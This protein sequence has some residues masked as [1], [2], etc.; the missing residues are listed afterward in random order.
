MELFKD[1]YLMAGI[2]LLFVSFGG[3]FWIA[4]SIQK[5]QEKEQSLPDSFSD[6]FT[7]PAAS[8][9]PLAARSS[10]PPQPPVPAR[11]SAAPVFITTA[12]PAAPESSFSAPPEDSAQIRQMRAAIEQIASQLEK[13]EGQMQTIAKKLDQPSPASA[14]AQSGAGNGKSGSAQIAELS[15]KIEKIYQVLATLSGSS[16]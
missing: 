5:K 15:T 1:V 4:R 16:R 11:P 9:P 14:D 2:A 3:I 6:I 10:I 8:A 7:A 13:I 12:P